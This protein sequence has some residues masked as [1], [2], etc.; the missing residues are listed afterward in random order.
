MFYE[1]SSSPQIMRLFGQLLIAFADMQEGQPNGMQMPGMPVMPGMPGSG[2]DGFPAPGNGA[3]GF[4][5]GMPDLSEM[6]RHVPPE[7]AAMMGFKFPEA[8]AD[9]GLYGAEDR[10][11]GGEY[12]AT[13]DGGHEFDENAIKPTAFDPHDLDLSKYEDCSEK[14]R[15]TKEP[16]RRAELRDDPHVWMETAIYYAHQM[17]DTKCDVEEAARCF[18][19]L[20]G[21]AALRRRK[22]AADKTELYDTAWIEAQN[23]I[24]VA[25]DVDRLDPTDF[26]AVMVLL[27]DPFSATT[28]FKANEAIEKLRDARD[29]AKTE[30]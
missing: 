22:V 24:Q 28:P 19:T 3:P 29:A 2:A 13:P 8:P 6:M 10:E 21:G 9:E 17:V 11:A 4:P 27:G 20:P 23:L 25:Y 14:E 1:K 7:V 30:A 18:L 5:G 16:D 26:Q 15:Q 12:V